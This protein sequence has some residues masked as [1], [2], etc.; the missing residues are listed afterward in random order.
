MSH[1]PSFLRVRELSVLQFMRGIWTQ[2]SL[3]W[4]FLL[5]SPRNYSSLYFCKKIQGFREYV[6]ISFNYTLLY[7]EGTKL[8]SFLVRFQVFGLFK[9][10]PFI[11]L[12]KML[13]LRKCKRE[14]NPKPSF[15]R[16]V[17]FQ[18]ILSLRVKV[19]K[20]VRKASLQFW[21]LLNFPDYCGTF[22]VQKSCLN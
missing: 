10:P 8:V 5:F 1:E 9:R 2:I 15:K 11:K 4:V 16:F 7:R 14:T 12:C 6:N 3:S 19:W 20:S 22:E 13:S 17:F 21:N 18:I